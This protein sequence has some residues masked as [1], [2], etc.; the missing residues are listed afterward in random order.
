MRVEEHLRERT[1]RRHH[2]RAE[3]NVRHKMAIHDVEVQPLGTRFLH[4]FGLGGKPAKVRRQQG[5][6][7]NHWPEAMQRN[8]WASMTRNGWR[9]PP[10]LLWTAGFSPLQRCDTK[11]R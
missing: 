5:R 1:D 8:R 4:A 6:R 10:N 2:L 3:G 11:Q 9:R 7:Y